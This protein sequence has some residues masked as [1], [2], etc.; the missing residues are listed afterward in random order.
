MVAND[1]SLAVIG[2]DIHLLHFS[3]INKSKHS[4]QMRDLL[5][6]EFCRVRSYVI[7]A[8]VSSIYPHSLNDL[9]GQHELTS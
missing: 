5:E 2:V 3:S 8:K 6:R 4:K 9:T 1:N 7:C